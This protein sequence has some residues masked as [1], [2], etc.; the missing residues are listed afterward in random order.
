MANNSTVLLSPGAPATSIKSN[1]VNFNGTSTIGFE[2]APAS[3]SYTVVNYGAAAAPN[4]TGLTGARGGFSLDTSD[5]N[6]QKVIAS[7]NAAQRTWSGPSGTWDTGT[8]TSWAEGDQL[9]FAGDS[10]TFNDPGDISTITLAGPLA[11][12]SVTVNN[13]SNP[14]TFSG[15]GLLTGLTSLVKTGTGTLT[16]EQANAYAGGTTV[17]GGTLISQNN[18]AF[19]AAGLIT[20]GDAGTGTD[21]VALLFANSVDPANP[22]T[23]SASGSGMAIIGTFGAGVAVNAT[24]LGGLITLNRPTTFESTVTDRLAINGQIT[25]NVGT[26]TFSG[27]SRTT[28]QSTANDFVGDIVVTGNG[29]IL[30]ASVGTVSETIPDA[31]NVTVEAGAFLHLTSSSGAE[32]INALNGDGVVRTFPTSALGSVLAVGSAGGS[33]TFSGMLTNGFSPLSLTKL[34]AGTQTLSG[35]ENTYTGTTTVNG[36]TLLVSGSIS[37]TA[38]VNLASGTL[39]LG[40]SDAINDGAAVTFA[41]GKLAT[42]GFSE[43]NATTAGLGILSLTANSSIDF[44]AGNSSQLL[45]AG[46]GDHTAGATL[47][48]LNWSGTP[49]QAG[50]TDDRLMF[51]GNEF[52]RLA[53]ESAFLKNDIFFNG[54]AGY[55]AIQFDADHF[56]IVAIPEPSTVSMLGGFALIGLIGFRARRGAHLRSSCQ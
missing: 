3:G 49:L 27:G 43:G 1:G 30:Q 29:T 53:F 38:Q 26:L 4:L 17:R 10:V 15:T 25:G 47:S 28:L 36:G 40:A 16:V 35:T 11:P 42:G 51:V 18:N 52:V 24:T 22:I 34:G 33:G 55:T 54:A 48:I 20:L 12:T 9:F 2:S 56:E 19:G 21:T 31:S 13:S 50:T 41:G 8:S 45:F 7:V 6:N 14:Y 46:V 5:G 37:G 23:V 44:G 39:L 32:T